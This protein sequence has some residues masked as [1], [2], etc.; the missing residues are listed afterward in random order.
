MLPGFENFD[1]R[2]ISILLYS[3]SVY[4]AMIA[5]SDTNKAAE[6]VGTANPNVKLDSSS[7]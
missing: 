3:D 2:C 1:G 4:G 6:M 5:I 7:C